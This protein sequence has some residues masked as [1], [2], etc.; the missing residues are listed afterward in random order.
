MGKHDVLEYLARKEQADAT[1]VASALRAPYAAAAMA[2]LRLLRQGLVAR[3]LD[4]EA[5][6]YWYQLTPKGEKR[7]RYLQ[8]FF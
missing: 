4:P 2:L 3:Y 6:L 5:H 7:L 1:E 8:Q